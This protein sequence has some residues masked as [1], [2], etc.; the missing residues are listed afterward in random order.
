MNMPDM[1]VSDVENHDML[2]IRGTSCICM[3][4][5]SSLRAS[6]AFGNDDFSAH[7]RRLSSLEHFYQTPFLNMLL[8]L[9]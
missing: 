1:K 9:A 7:N 5:A 8:M 2:L 4:E 6:S 3:E